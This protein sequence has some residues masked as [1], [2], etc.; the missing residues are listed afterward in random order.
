MENLI[1]LLGNDQDEMA[2]QFVFSE[3]IDDH[4]EDDLSL[5][6][7][8]R[9]LLLTVDQLSERVSQDV[10]RLEQQRGPI[11]DKNFHKNRRGYVPVGLLLARHDALRASFEPLA[12]GIR[13]T[14]RRIKAL[15]RRDTKIFYPQNY[16]QFR[17]S[18]Y[19]TL[20]APPVSL[21]GSAVSC[22]ICSADCAS[23]VV[24]QRRCIWCEGHSCTCKTFRMCVKCS[25]KW[26]WKSSELFSKSFA[27]CPSCRAEYCLEDI[28]TYELV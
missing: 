2:D 8:Y 12:A 25:V 5:F 23:A 28:V 24:I 26:Y 3:A 10:E 15:D 27:T 16:H 14:K 19:R 6:H 22:S 1:A 7:M 9:Q 18:T 11:L 17:D 21:P 4:E 20:V 13:A